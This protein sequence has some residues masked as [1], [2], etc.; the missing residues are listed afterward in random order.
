MNLFIVILALV[1]GAA[2]AD[3]CLKGAEVDCECDGGDM[4]RAAQATEAPFKGPWV[5]TGHKAAETWEAKNRGVQGGGYCPSGG[6]PDCASGPVP[7]AL[8]PAWGIVD[9]NKANE[10]DP[11][12]AEKMNLV[13]PKL[14]RKGKDGG[15]ERC[16]VGGSERSGWNTMMQGDPSPRMHGCFWKSCT[17][18]KAKAGLFGHGAK[19]AKAAAAIFKKAKTVEAQEEEAKK[20]TCN[21]FREHACTPPLA[22]HD[23][24]VAAAACMK[25]FAGQ[26]DNNR[27]CDDLIAKCKGHP[28]SGR[29]GCLT[30]AAAGE[31]NTVTKHKTQQPLKALR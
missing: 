12:K 23:P 4:L 18:T 9:P 27:Y 17:D 28:P 3:E 15:F 11:R 24:R 2:S 29:E 10:Q 25:H 20:T 30:K 26:V 16:V 22:S 19:D 31:A 14:I 8:C 1:F 7:V 21:E 13:C 5:H 6:G